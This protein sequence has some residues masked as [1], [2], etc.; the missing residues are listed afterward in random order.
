MEKKIIRFTAHYR[1][2]RKSVSFKVD[3]DFANVLAEMIC[4]RK[5][6]QTSGGECTMDNNTFEVGGNSKAMHI[7]LDIL[8]TEVQF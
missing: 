6:L 5:M 2:A 1:D 3:E 7:D 8:S 4:M